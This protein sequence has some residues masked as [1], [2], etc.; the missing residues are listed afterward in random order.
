[1]LALVPVD[2]FGYKLMLFL[3]LLSVIVAFAPN[4]VWPFVSVRLKKEGKP[5]G[6][7][8]AGLA[9]G[10]TAKITGP[11]VI[12]AGVIGC[13]LVGMSKPEGLDE[14]IFTFGQTWVSLALLIWFVIIGILYGLV[15]PAEKQAA[16]GD[17][18]AD[19]KLSMFGGILHLLLALELILMI[20]KPGF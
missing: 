15:V 4:F 5:V 13:G 7:T 11:A 12:V 18:E 3:H 1:M 14:G 6:P 19:K 2:T 16:A 8:Y 20:W 9:S 10:N 17:A